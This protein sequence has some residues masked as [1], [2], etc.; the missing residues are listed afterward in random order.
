MLL[1]LAI[2][3]IFTAAVGL[4]VV[5]RLLLPKPLSGIP[6]NT[7]SAKRLLGDIPGLMSEMSG[8]GDFVAWLIEENLKSGS[9]INQIFLRPF[10]KPFVV[11]ADHREARDIQMNRTKEFD[12]TD[13]ILY[14]FGPLMRSNQLVLKTGPEWKLHRRLVQDTMSPAFLHRV[15]APSMYASSLRFIERWKAK[16]AVANGRPF[17]A[18]EDIS[19]ATLD[20]AFAFTFG[21]DFPH[22]AT[23]PEIEG[24]DYSCIEYCQSPDEPIK[25]ASPSQE[26]EVHSILKLVEKVGT[27]QSSPSPWL[28]WKLIANSLSF[29]RCQSTKDACI[30]R[31][32]E[33]AMERRIH[34]PSSTDDSWIKNTV[35][36][37]INREENLA[38]NDGREPDFFSP[39]ILDELYG[40]LVAGHD[41]TSTTL[42]WGVKLLA[43][44]PAAQS[45]LRGSL[46][47]TFASALRDDRLP[48]I[49]EIIETSVPYLDAVIEEILRVGRTVPIGSRQATQDTVLL[50][51]AIPKDTTVLYLN[52]G[53]SYFLPAGEIDESRRSPQ[54]QEEKRNGNAPSWD[55]SDAS[56]FRPERWLKK[57]SSSSSGKP[58]KDDDFVFNSQAGPINTFGLGLRGCFGRRLAYVELRIMLVMM[59]W[60]LELLRCPAELSG[61][62][63]KLVH[64]GK[65]Q[66]CFVRLNAVKNG[67]L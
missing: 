2:I 10:S 29:R 39:M 37:V 16:A 11:L 65:P 19:L 44:H 67:E 66:Q 41:T 21:P 54:S 18:R 36:L 23:K 61:Y 32:I 38:R 53:R 17:E 34:K 5:Y 64:T 55:A 45:R 46:Q 4:Y 9:M 6:Y 24:L 63:S 48:T 57:T 15:V 47:A 22:Q 28:K 56:L 52:H 62:A 60:N 12:R 35:E 49:H 31:E 8:R 40:F 20:A 27:V 51:Y 50:G 13:D 7:E 3:F 42:D 33:K 26:Q 30:R 58:Q 59:I 25:F 43:D 1:Y 14:I